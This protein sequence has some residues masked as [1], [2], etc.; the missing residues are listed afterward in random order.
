MKG[1]A[2]KIQKHLKFLPRKFLLLG[3][4]S[5]LATSVLFPIAASASAGELTGRWRFDETVA[6]SIAIDS[7]GNNDAIPTDDPIPS[8]TVAPVT[9]E[10]PRSASF[11]GSN[12]FTIDRPASTDFTICAWVKTSSTGGGTEH[13]TSAPI[14][15]SETGGVDYDFGFGVGNG[16]R[17]MFGNGGDDVDYGYLYD[18]QVNGTT[19]INDNAWHNVCVTR[20]NTSGMVKLYVDAQLD[21]SGVT[22]IGPLTSNP[23]ARIGYGY[24][25]AALFEGLIDDVRVYDTDLTPE[26]LQSLTDG[27]DN[28]FDDN[29]GVS[30]AVENA[31][32][33]GD[34]NNDGISDSE[35]ANV[36]SFVNPTTNE[37]VTLAV[38]SSCQLS[39]VNGISST[40][41]VNDSRYSYPVGLI[42]FTASCG[43]PGYSA[44]VSQ[45][46]YKAPDGDFVLRKE[47]SGQYQTVSGAT[48]SRQTLHDNQVLIA[49]YSIVDGSSLDDDG[50][51]NGI[52]VDPAGPARLIPGVPS[53]GVGAAEPIVNVTILTHLIASFAITAL[54]FCAYRLLKD[55]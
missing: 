30:D 16:G 28:P 22:G 29:D 35:Q 43:T 14:M 31:A 25:G 2:I 49:S 21:G 37:Y 23:N 41:L 27:A 6:G 32:P 7:V 20:N 38:P 33:G 34:G 17:L 46:Y 39:T 42:G 4:A 47:R 19:Q 8:T 44:M 11:D 50:V 52:I 12:Y 13:W 45:Y 54:G 24:D 51:A 40:T 18:A 55:S 3:L 36:A 1:F 26:Q 15:D 53:T 5:L 48:F 10:N 9:F